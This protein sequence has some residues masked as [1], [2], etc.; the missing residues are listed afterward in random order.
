MK[1]L[2][3]VAM[4]LSLAGLAGA[5][6]AADDKDVTGTWKWTTERQGQK[7]ETTLKLK[8]EG[9]KVTGAVSSNFGGKDAETKIE[10]GKYKEGELSFTVTRE[11][12]DQKF[13]TKYSGKVTGDTINGTAVSERDGKENKRD[14]EAKKAKD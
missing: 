7:T 10:N 11:F 6:G 4:A 8:A 9:E 14:W 1:T 5:A 3:S 12:K 2:M 13:T